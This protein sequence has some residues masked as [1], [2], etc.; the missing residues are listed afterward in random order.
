MDNLSNIVFIAYAVVAAAIGII[1]KRA[2]TAFLLCLG[3]GVL[4]FVFLRHNHVYIEM[5]GLLHTCAFSGFALLVWEGK[6]LWRKRREGDSGK[7]S[8]DE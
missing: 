3:M 1:S 6:E 8:Q 7:R 5:G 4:V 2:L